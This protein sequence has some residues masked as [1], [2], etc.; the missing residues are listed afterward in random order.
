MVES[1]RDKDKLLEQLVDLTNQQTDVLLGEEFDF[2]YFDSLM[3]EKEELVNQLNIYETG[4]EKVY[5]RVKEELEM[6]KEKYKEQITLMQQLIRSI[7]E[8]GVL[9]KASEMKNKASWE[10]YSSMKKKEIRNFKVNKSNAA[11]Y[12]Q[13]M[14]N[15]HQGQSYFLDKKK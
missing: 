11:K 2:D 3:S 7:T 9:L 6:N 10:Q 5:N 12:Y 1:L 4:F 14:S 8:K 15:Q 13:N